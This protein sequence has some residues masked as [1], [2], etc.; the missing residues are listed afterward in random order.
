M[1]ARGSRVSVLARIARKVSCFCGRPIGSKMFGRG[2]PAGGRNAGS[3]VEWGSDAVAP[4][5]FSLASISA[6]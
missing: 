4:I 2:S 3:D 6:A 5:A 1:A